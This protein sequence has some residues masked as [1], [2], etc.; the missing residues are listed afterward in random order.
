MGG[1]FLAA[2]AQEEPFGPKGDFVGRTDEQTDGLSNK[3]TDGRTEGRTSG[4]RELDSK[5]I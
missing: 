5:T 4:L 1:S 2:A 3:R